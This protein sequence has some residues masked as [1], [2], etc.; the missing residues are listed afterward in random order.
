MHSDYDYLLAKLDTFIRKYYKDRLIRGALYSV[1][2]VVVVFLLAASLEAFGHFGVSART[3]LFWVSVASMGFIIGRFVV[4][5]VIKLMRLGSIISHTEAA[6]I[7]GEHFGDVRDKLLNTL[8]LRSQGVAQSGSRALIEAAVAQRSKELG[9]VPFT[10]AI[11]LRRNTKYLRYALPPLA[12]LAVLLFAAPSFITGS[13]KRLIEHGKEFIAE[14]PFRFVILND[15][16]EVAE[17]QDFEL[18]VELTGDAIPQQVD[19][20]V[21]GQHIPLVKQSTVR[22]LHRFRNVRKDVDF[23]VSAEGFHSVGYTLKAVPHPLLLGVDLT[24]SY[25][26][27]LGMPEESVR[28]SGDLTI[29]AGTRITWNIGARSADRM[30]LAFDDT[31]YSTPPSAGSDDAPVFRFSRRLLQ[32]RTY[33]LTP[34]FGGRTAAEAV[35]HRLEVIP[36]LYPSIQVASR[37]DSSALKRLFFN[38]EVSDDHGVRRLLFHYRFVQGGDSVPVDR[39]SGVMEL[40]ID[41]RSTRQGF[42][43]GWDLYDLTI[44]PGDRIEHWFEVWDNDGVNGSKSTRTAAQVFAAPTTRE[45]MEK[46]DASSEAIQG[47]LRENIREAQDL[48]RELDKL[49]RELLEKK[50]S[51]WKDKQKLQEVLERQKQLQ[52]RIEHNSEQ[53]RQSQQEQREFNPMDERLLEKQQQ[54]QELFENVLSDEMKELYRKVEEMLQQVDKEKLQDQ[55]REMKLGQEDMEKEMDRALEF[56]KRMEVEQKAEDLAEQ[57]REMAERQK[58]LSEKSKEGKEESEALK[59]QQDELNKEFEALREQMDELQKKN[60]ALEEPMNIPDTDVQE[61]GIQED[62]KQSSDQ[63]GKGQ[64]QKAGGAQKSA[65]EKMEQLAFQMESAMGGGEQEQQEEDMDALRQ[66]LENIVQLSFDQEALMNDLAGTSV[67]DP[68]FTEH[69]R[70][71]REL[72]D[73][74]KVIED[75]L[76]A[77]SKRVP[78]LQS[79]VNREMNAVNDNMDEARRMLGEARANERF[80]PMATDKQQHAMTSLNNLALL[81]DEALQQMMQQMMAQSK[82]GSG[83]CKKPGGT[84]SGQGKKP[85]MSK[86]KA[87]QE[88]LQKQ[89][90]QMRK[91]MQEGKAKGEKPGRENPGGMGMPGMS[92]QLVQLAAQQAAIRKEMQ[93]MGQEMN[94]D[95]SGA[96]NELNRLAQQMEQQERDIVNR[97]I[98]PE[99]MRRQQDIMTRLLE[100]EKAERERE[101]DQK[102]TSNEGHEQP[103]TDPARVFEQQ[104]RKAREAELLRTLPP[105]LKPYYRDRVNAYFGT[106]DR[107]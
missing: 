82:P 5:P 11:D 87:Q 2:L 45:L 44:M 40:R 81:L 85:S 67:R 88:A 21:G 25:P 48:Q 55:L 74:A 12:V 73:D 104:R 79:I 49:R 78:Q 93:R 95:G 17:D 72:R 57:L 103:P 36:D 98:T 32:S 38:G 100:H 50:E 29:P 31:S 4:L 35:R 89:L 20:E 39:R 23:R 69:S 28:N 51:D 99:T 16:L 61:Q 30:Q 54:I 77:L 66:L 52:E 62:Q 94:K 101:L 97:N 13:A 76:F 68:R 90:E 58:E 37:T 24:L 84:G 6:R 56:F 7:V 60:E 83:S 10:N 42:F 70:T 75:S 34:S 15:T 63:L 96:G 1:G 9:P 91:A 92:Q 64:K 18:V 65:A 71:Q 26:P 107:P 86:M 102:R 80:K 43:H 33:Q 53:L 106:F 8:Q 22:F 3:A 27:Y 105:G 19:L 47:T 41:P 46:R 14:A 59:Q